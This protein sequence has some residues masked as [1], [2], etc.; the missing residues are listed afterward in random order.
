[1]RAGM[2]TDPGA[3]AITI[4]EW[5]DRWQAMQD[6][7]PSTEA[8]REYQIR[9]FILPYWD[10]RKLNSLTG[11]DITVWQRKLHDVEGMSRRTAKDARGLLHTILG[12]AAA[13]EPPLIPSI[14]PSA[15][16]TGGEDRPQA[17]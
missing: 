7:G 3:G 9:R 4:S 15:R 12:D 6:V 17:P 13:A 14:P 16:A 5:I 8:N 1:M 2:W 11:E 10:K